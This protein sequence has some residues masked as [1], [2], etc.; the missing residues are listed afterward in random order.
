MESKLVQ[1][2]KDN[3]ENLSNKERLESYYDFWHK[4]KNQYNMLRNS[5][6]FK[7]LK[8]SED[9][10]AYR[11]YLVQWV[12]NLGEGSI[13]VFATFYILYVQAFKEDEEDKEFN[14]EDLIKGKI[15]EID[16]DL[17]KW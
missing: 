17:E 13:E 3:H 4:F 6:T 2:V 1:K 10:L 9:R 12:N 14:L 15:K 8:E 7:I 11:D 16:E 5:E